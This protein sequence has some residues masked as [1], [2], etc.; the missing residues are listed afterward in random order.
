MPDPEKFLKSAGSWYDWWPRPVVTSGRVLL[1]LFVG[2][3]A[4]LLAVVGLILFSVGLLLA[5]A[6]CFVAAIGVGW[7][8]YR[9]IRTVA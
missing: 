5:G 7:L 2:F 8:A 6:L 3:L 1:A 4:F 9:A